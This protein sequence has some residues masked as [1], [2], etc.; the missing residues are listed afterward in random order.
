[1]KGLIFGTTN[2]GKLA[3]AR[4]IL[5]VSVIGLALDVDEIQSL[6][7]R[8]VAVK[9]AQAY[10]QKAKKPLFIE[11]VSLIFAEFSLLPGTYIDAFSKALGN[12]GLA[13]LLKGRKNRSATAITT[14]VYIYGTNKYEV[15][16]GVVKGT[17]AK[18]PRGDGFGW[19]PIF[20]PNGQTKT[21][22]EMDLK[23]KNK[24][25]MR[26]KALRK[27]KKW[28]SSSDKSD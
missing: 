20:I 18:T 23:T 25:S 15:F 9:K 26:K 11:D 28:L 13:E 21:F 12:N 19:D 4:D 2:E 1:M 8:E 17:V 3:E 6:D 24:Y 27:F 14:I 7:N 22:G 16:E 10:F 5:D